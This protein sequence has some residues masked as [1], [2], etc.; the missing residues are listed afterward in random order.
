MVQLG[1][2]KGTEPK[3]GVGGEVEIPSSFYWT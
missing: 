3:I 1:M 2:G